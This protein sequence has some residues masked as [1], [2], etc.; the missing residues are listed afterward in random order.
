ME[1][2]L[3]VRAGGEGEGGKGDI[4]PVVLLYRSSS[5]SSSQVRQYSISISSS[6]Q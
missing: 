2:L 3:G 5:S 6:A 1:A 4:S